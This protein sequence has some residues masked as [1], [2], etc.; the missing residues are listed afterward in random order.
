MAINYSIDS[1]ERIVYLEPSGESSLSEWTS[2]MESVLADASYQR[3]FN[4]L[5][6]R[7]R[8][9]GAPDVAFTRGAADF[10]SRHRQ[11]MG[12]F[13][14]ASVA[15]EPATLGLMRMF[16]IFLEMK[17]VKGVE[18]EAFVDYE[19]AKQWLLEQPG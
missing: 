14:W 19:E 3:D 10:V 18:T 16:G 9:D 2:A 13:K 7:R 5:T 12:N 8:Q 15:G 6:D 11:H 17:N 4:F 1:E